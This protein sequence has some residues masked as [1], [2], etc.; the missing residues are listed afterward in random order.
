MKHQP[1]QEVESINGVLRFR[2]NKIID[3]LFNSGAL[4][5]NKIAVMEFPQE[6]RIQL[7]QLL[8][9]SLSGFGE[10]SYVDETSYQLAYAKA[11]RTGDEK[12]L[13]IAVLQERLQKAKDGMRS[14]VAELYEI[15]PDD[16]K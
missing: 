10:L 12:D 1:M 3:F 16:L 2:R 15:C 11:E 8:G 9:Y 5:L 4:D 14:A 13:L 7:A 6:D